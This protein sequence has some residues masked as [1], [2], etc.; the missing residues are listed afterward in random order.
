MQ[1]FPSYITDG[2]GGGCPGERRALG[3]TPARRTPS[4]GRAGVS[5]V[6]V[7]LW[8]ALDWAA[9]LQTRAGPSRR[10]ANMPRVAYVMLPFFARHTDCCAMLR[11]CI[12]ADL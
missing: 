10:G 6:A 9:V 2:K 4:W 3:G 1:M 5:A 8:R 7:L 12:K 11:C